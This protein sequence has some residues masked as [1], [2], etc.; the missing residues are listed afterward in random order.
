MKQM[1]C[2]PQVAF[3][4]QTDQTTLFTDLRL[5]AD[6][7][8]ANQLARDLR[9]LPITLGASSTLRLL[10]RR[11][12]AGTAESYTLQIGSNG[13]EIVGASVVALHHG[14]TTLKMLLATQGYRLRHGIAQVTPAFA[15]R[16]IMLDVSRGKMASLTYLK[17]LVALMADLQYNILQLYSEDKLALEKHPKVGALT[18]TYDQA[19][20]RELDA[21]CRAHF[22]EL[23]PC[24]QTYSHMHGLLT[25][26]GYSH[27]AENDGLFSLAAGN[28]DVYAFLEDELRETL[29]WFSS[30]T[31][32][33]NMDEAYDIGT[34][35]SKEAVAQEGSGQVF[36]AHICRVVAIARKH[37]AQ[38]ILLWGDIAAKY[39]QLLHALPENVVVVDWNYN[40]QETYPSLDAFD[41]YPGAFW[42]AGGVSTWNSIFPRMYNA[43]TNLAT[44]STQARQKGATGFLVTDWGDY[45]HMQPLGLSLYG[46]LVG[47]NQAYCAGT[48]AAEMSEAAL[49]PLLFCDQNVAEAFR[50][51]M[52]SNLS[53]HL[54][55]GFKTMSIYYFFDDM[56]CGLAMRGS[57][58]YPQLTR[59]TFPPLL[60]CGERACTLLAQALAD[61]A[62]DRYPYPDENWR[63]LFGRSFV[64]ELLLSARMTRYIGQKGRLCFQILDALADP[65][66]VGD[67]LLALVAAIRM[68]YAELV[69]IRRLFDEVWVLRADRRGIESAMSL[70]DTAG[71]QL[72]QTV[73]WLA[74]QRQGLLRGEPLDAGLEHYSAGQ[75]CRILWTADYQNLWDRAYPWQ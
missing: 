20:I 72:G 67:D 40:P 30:T 39:P 35:F 8:I 9:A 63:A 44:F 36:L 50:L 57:Q 70:F 13:I 73:K 69:E 42:A 23:Q 60:A 37:G 11:E 43:C 12:L 28:E 38:T 16:G 65:A 33:I 56:L 32:N 49:H 71:V 14:L 2:I 59:E 4:H 41:G 64:L 45:G 27:L 62:F 46:Y 74:Q 6:T 54:Q 66:T 24:I 75:A 26:P 68:L 19:Q 3:S 21:C 5:E 17:Q 61:A 25:V 18:G 15:H 31:L 22:I 51:L 29:P 48:P 1:P 7:A 34:G 55:T 52:D 47:A 58:H 53:P 10:L